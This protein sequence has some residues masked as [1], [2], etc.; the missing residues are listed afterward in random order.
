MCTGHSKVRK[1]VSHSGDYREMWTRASWGKSAIEAFAALQPNPCTP[2]FSLIANLGK[3]SAQR[4]QTQC[5]WFY[6]LK[7]TMTFWWHLCCGVAPT[8]LGPMY[9]REALWH[10]MRSKYGHWSHTELA[11][12]P[13]SSTNSWVN[14]E[15]YIISPNLSYY[16]H[17][18]GQWL[19]KKTW[20]DEGLYVTY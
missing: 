18:M 2:I 12:K 20:K 9:E 11:P 3:L 17:K 6:Y 5:A 8:G 1:H 14:G 7:E 13:N 10:C 15:N 19:R 16:M 4:S